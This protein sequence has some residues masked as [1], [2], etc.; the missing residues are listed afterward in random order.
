MFKSILISVAIAPVLLGVI[1]ATGR[2]SR[3]ARSALTVAWVAYAVLWFGAL[4]FLR[5]R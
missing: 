1:A 4:Y 2:D 5:L 3:R